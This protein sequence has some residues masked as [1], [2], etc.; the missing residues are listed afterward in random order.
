MK[1]IYNW[2][3][4]TLVLALLHIADLFILPF[5]TMCDSLAYT[6]YGFDLAGASLFDSNEIPFPSYASNPYFP[7][8]YPLILSF[9]ISLFGKS[10]F[11][12]LYIFQ[13]SLIVFA[14]GMFLKLIHNSK[15]ILISAFLLFF[16]TPEF[17]IYPQSVMSEGPAISL[18]AILILSLI[19]FI[20][21]GS[22]LSYLFFAIS[23]IF[24][25][26]IRIMPFPVITGLLALLFLFKQ[27]NL[28]TAL[29]VE[30]P[31]LLGIILVP[32]LNLVLIG[33]PVL[34][35]SSG[36]HLHDR[37]IF[38]HN[39]P[40]IEDNEAQKK[41]ISLIGEDKY[42]R[43]HWEVEGSL[44]EA[45]LDLGFEVD[46]LLKS[47]STPY[48]KL[49]PLEILKKTLH[50]SWKTLSSTNEH[51]FGISPKFKTDAVAAENQFYIKPMGDLWA[52]YLKDFRF[53]YISYFYLFSIA[54]ILL[55]GSNYFY[56]II[57]LYPLIGIL[58]SSVISWD[59]PRR[60]REFIMSMLLLGLLCLTSKG[61]Q[62]S[63][64]ES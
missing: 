42:R 5:G 54:I 63:S 12:P 39:F 45:G 59:D 36:K 19:Q 58:L 14:Q 52:N 21:N 61:K 9:F 3:F 13:H 56:L 30:A 60:L 15:A 55:R 28:K 32:V 57:S 18:H 1:T 11:L 6:S 62:T 43:P 20:K 4:F 53:N 38:S 33:K 7:I 46:N 37:T 64:S 25:P 2:K 24:L 51:E 50:F 8:G 29:K 26:M 47:A 17:H 40:L 48:F 31:C 23:A 22:G 41:I 34:T 44:K 49:Y 27:I 10:F 16:L 35:T